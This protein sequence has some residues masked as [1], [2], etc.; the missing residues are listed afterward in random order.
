V[1]SKDWGSAVIHQIPEKGNQP[2]VSYRQGGDDFILIDYGYG[3]FDLNYRCR[4]V[5][6]YQKLKEQ[7]GDIS[8]PDGMHTGMACG[9]SLMLYYDGLKIPRQK[10][11]DLLLKLEAEIGDLSE[12]KL[13]CRKFKLPLTFKSKKQ[14][15][16]IQRYIETQRPYA[17]YLPDTMDF[18]AKNNA[19]T[20]QQ[21]RDVF[22]NSVLMVVAVGFF[23]A[24]PIGLP[25][26]P[27]K[28]MNCPKMN[29][30]RVFTPEG[31]A[32]WGGSCMALYNVESPGGYMPTGLT[33]PGVD[34]LGSKK[35]YSAE[36]PWLFEDFDQI[37]FYEVS[38]EEYE[39]Q[40]AIFHSGRYEYEWE[41]V[42]FDLKEHNQLLRDT[43]QEV[44]KIRAEQREAQAKMDKLEKELLEKWAKEK[45]EGKI[46]MDTV[47]ELLND[48]D[49]SPI[50]APLNANVWKVE[51]KEGDKIEKEKIVTILEAMKLEIPVRAEEDMVGWTVEKVLV[52][53]N[54][55]VQAGNP[56]ILLRKPE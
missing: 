41:D 12:A 42:E 2:L 3:A 10:I 23:C 33:I 21:F 11:L 5:A 38:E 37:T 24:L 9:N 54:D 40:M 31:Q 22:L 26:D 55:V 52:K 16:A 46:S 56:L 30:S 14:D 7:K 19:F 47:E 13:P 48:P 4:A 28:R 49:I 50:E 32:S 36:K 45:E 27:R 6:L 35:G 15:M 53:P 17:S 43:K 39:K 20:D 29:P 25:I 44:E 1:H 18:V 51:I 8:F 34:I